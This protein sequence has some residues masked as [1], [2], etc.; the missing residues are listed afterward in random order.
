MTSLWVEKKI[1]DKDIN[2]FDYKEFSNLR[3]IGS[4]GYSVVYK[5]NWDFRGMK[6]AALRILRN[7]QI[8]KEIEENFVKEV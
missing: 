1:K 4:G 6:V 8:D 5:A 2:Y 7:S 3:E